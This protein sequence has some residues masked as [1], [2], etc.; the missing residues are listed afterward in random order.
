MRT[1]IIAILVSAH[2]AYATDVG[3]II[4]TN[5]TWTLVDS[6]YT[7]VSD[8][9]IG[10]DATLLIEPGCVV[11]GDDYYIKVWGTLNAVG[12]RESKITLNDVFISTQYMPI[13]FNK[14]QQITIKFAELNGSR[15]YAS[16]WGYLVLQDSYL[17][18]ITSSPSVDLFIPKLDCYIERNIFE[19][20]Q[21]IDIIAQTD[22]KIYI[23][24]NVFYNSTNSAI[25]MGGNSSSEIIIQ[26]NNFLNTDRIAL[27][28]GYCDEPVNI[29]AT[30]NYW[31]TT[32]PPIIEFNMIHDRDDD[33]GLTQYIVY[34]PFLAEPDLNTPTIF[35]PIHV[36]TVQT[37]PSFVT[38]VTPPLGQDMI[39]GL[40]DISADK[41][42]NCPDVYE[43]DQWEGDVIDSS[44]AN[45]SV[46]MDADKTITAVF[47]ATR[48]CGDYCH[49]YP[50]G[51]ASKDCEVNLQDIALLASNWLACTKPECD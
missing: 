35:L 29:V 40:V 16:E 20:I 39:G 34:T 38:S 13:S 15:I 45:S 50:L 43:F 1:I 36:L 23:R 26:Y 11:D 27:E 48:N 28:L 8:I 24:N 49:P 12:N 2:I 31:N 32:N 4:S 21:G 7:L 6:P 10:E 17:S 41:Y 22:T 3:G 42:N 9:Q 33:L 47:K 18:S 5:T 37:R 44:S 14:Y 51:D 19:N 46:F 25:K 30:N